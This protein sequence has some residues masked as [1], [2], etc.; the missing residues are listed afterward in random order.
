MA[1]DLAS[2]VAGRP[3]WRVTG[4]VATYRPVEEGWSATVRPA[5][6]PG[7]SFER[8]HVAVVSPAGAASSTS[9]ATTVAEAVRVAERRVR[10]RNAG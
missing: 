3:G 10:G 8:W 5:T 9:W 6:A 1:D 4:P 7:R 2:H